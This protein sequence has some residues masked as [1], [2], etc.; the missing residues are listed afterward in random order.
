MTRRRAV[1]LWIAVAATLAGAIWLYTYRVPV[2]IEYVDHIG[3]SRYRF[4]PTQHLR[5]QAWWSAYATVALL[6]LGG[7]AVVW[8]LP[9]RSASSAPSESRS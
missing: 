9:D 3:R 1:C 6:L 5:E 8:L 7:A 4:H 2:T